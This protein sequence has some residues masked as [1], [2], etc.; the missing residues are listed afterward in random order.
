MIW[1]S[2][3]F[4]ACA[5][6]AYA[7]LSGWPVFLPQ[8]MRACVAVLVLVAGLGVWA[9]RR[10]HKDLRAKS[11]RVARWM[12]F[13]VIGGGVL[14]LECAFLWIFAVAPQSLESVGLE[15][16]RRFRPEDAAL[17]VVADRDVSGSRAGN[18]LWTRDTRRPLP[19]RTD[20]KPGMK[21]EVFIRLEDR[22]DAAELLKGKI[23]VR[24]F[25]LGKYERESWSPLAG[26][27][28][29]LRAE[30]DGFVRIAPER[31][32][33]RV[34]HEVFHAA[35]PGGQN[36]FT[37]LAGASVAGIAPLTRI[38]DGVFLLPPADRIGGYQYRA[39]SSPLRIEELADGELV[40]PPPGA[41]GDLL[42]LPESWKF[43]DRLRVMARA[44][45]GP[46]SLKEQLVQLQKYLRESLQYSLVT[47]NPRDM[48]PIENFLFEEK[49]GHCE[50]FATAGALMARSLG[51]P[52]RVAYGWSGGKWYESAGMFVFRANEAHAWTEVL[53]DGR[54][55][56]VMDPTPETGP[57]G[58]ARVAEPDEKIP[59]A[60]D[61]ESESVMS[62]AS[63]PGGGD[64]PRLA[65]WLMAAFAFPAA[66]IALVRWRRRFREGVSVHM[67]VSSVDAVAPGYLQL[68]RQVCAGHGI[69]IP[70]GQ[71]LRC[72]VARMKER[73]EFADELVRYHY[74]TRYEGR[75]V[76]A[77][78]EKSLVRKIRAWRDQSA[79]PPRDT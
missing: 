30:D 51:I 15:I 62:N 25:A 55:W 72:Q 64:F 48:D 46:G 47:T 43:A 61:R 76:D 34:V 28:Q 67:P 5:V 70:P 56:V 44:A 27:A 16:E 39:A 40:R 53:L 41:A 11:R 58:R 1:R 69:A 3:V 68:W 20:F 66:L 49:R 78:F 31:S 36:V 42:G 50:Y 14:T 65:L 77:G 63:S 37:A 21:P 9:A 4:V 57:G 17:R 23:Y 19:R 45:A 10:P 60:P 79:H 33:R 71:T 22:V 29:E 12:D 73:P 75:P 54:G 2:M 59:A 8:V 32:G 26:A 38:D 13:A 6:A 52:S 24:A 7:L 74:M 35:D 18:W